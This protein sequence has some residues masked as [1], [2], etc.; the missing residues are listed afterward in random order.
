[1]DTRIETVTHHP[2]NPQMYSSCGK[3]P[4]PFTI[5]GTL[6]LRPAARSAIVLLVAGSISF[7]TRSAL[8]REVVPGVE[9]ASRTVL[10]SVALTTGLLIADVLVPMRRRSRP[11]LDRT[12]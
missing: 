6:D 2:F 12:P 11:P 8:N 4:E 7:S 9:S 1:M 10:I 3:T 5:A